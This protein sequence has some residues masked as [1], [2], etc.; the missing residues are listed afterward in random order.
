MMPQ[1]L[2]YILINI[3]KN[4]TC[5]DFIRISSLFKTLKKV[6]LFKTIPLD[7]IIGHNG[8]SNNQNGEDYNSKIFDDINKCISLTV[9][10]KYLNKGKI[11]EQEASYYKSILK[12]YFKDL[13]F[14]HDSN[15]LPHYLNNGYSDLITN[16]NFALH[17]NRI[18]YLIKLCK[19]NIGQIISKN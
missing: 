16:D 13:I 8:Y 10:N 15:A 12:E 9:K 7:S 4:N 1:I 6:M 14:A 11:N 3:Q 17:K 18:Q 5:R 19:N 2:E